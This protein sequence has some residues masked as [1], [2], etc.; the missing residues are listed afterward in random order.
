MDAI[1]SRAGCR[2]QEAKRHIHRVSEIARFDSMREE[3]G[4]TDLLK[5]PI[6]KC[7]AYACELGYRRSDVWSKCIDLSRIIK[8]G[9]L[10]T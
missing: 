9:E 3:N 7:E 5:I 1:G 8:R 2:T 4:S 10:K 6:D